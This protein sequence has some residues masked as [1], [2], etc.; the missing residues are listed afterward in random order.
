LLKVKLKFIFENMDARSADLPH[1]DS[2]QGWGNLANGWLPA[3]WL[4]PLL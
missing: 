4:N 1:R 3:R 2:R